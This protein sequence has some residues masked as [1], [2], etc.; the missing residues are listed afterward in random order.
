MHA[1]DRVTPPYLA[2]SRVLL[3]DDDDLIVRSLQHAL[4]AEGC[5]VDTARN[6]AMAAELMSFREYAV[7]V[8]DPYLTGEV[9]HAI[10]ILGSIRALQP[11]S[12]LIVLTAYPSIELSAEARAQRAVG[13]IEKPKPLPFLMHLLIAVRR[14]AAAQ[15]HC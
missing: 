10:P 5:D 3:I 8:V 15:P 7:I 9:A 12:Q 1:A 2:D 6:A 14:V 13:V 4:L 11:R